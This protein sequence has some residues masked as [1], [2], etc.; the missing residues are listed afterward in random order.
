[1]KCQVNVEEATA[2]TATKTTNNTSLNVAFMIEPGDH[3]C[4]YVF[5]STRHHLQQSAGN[6][7]FVHSSRSRRLSRWSLLQ[8]NAQLF[9]IGSKQQASS[10]NTNV[11]TTRF[12]ILHSESNRCRRP[13]RPSLL[14]AQAQKSFFCWQNYRLGGP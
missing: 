14:E 4:K 12:L 6:P 5:L 8:R 3:G 2:P 11:A 13:V 10:D 1:M 7:I 9:T